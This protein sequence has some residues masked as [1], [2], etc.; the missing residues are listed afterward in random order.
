MKKFSGATVT[1]GSPSNPY[2]STTVGRSGNSASRQN[3][4]KSSCGSGAAKAFLYFLLIVALVAVVVVVYY[5]FTLNNKKKTTDKRAGGGG[6]SDVDY[7]RYSSPEAFEEGEPTR[8]KSKKSG[9][10]LVYFHMLGC[11]YCRKFDPTWNTFKSRFGSQLK[12]EKNV[13]LVSY[14]SDDKKAR[15]FDVRGFPTVLLARADSDEI[16]ATFSGERTVPNL[17]KFVDDNAR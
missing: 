9:Y 12:S 8:K 2:N 10:R 13:R 3:A 11:V 4:S 17:K 15:N 7:V 14:G 6:T 16:V 1:R 5:A